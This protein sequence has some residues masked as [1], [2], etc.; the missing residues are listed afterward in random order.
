LYV[1]PEPALDAEMF[2]PERPL[3]TDGNGGKEF[4]CMWTRSLEYSFLIFRPSVI[5]CAGLRRPYLPIFYKVRMNRF[6]VSQSK[7]L[8]THQRPDR[9]FVESIVSE[10]EN[11]S[12]DRSDQV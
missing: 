3:R 11:G 12:N 6:A 7:Q 10:V 1:E 9:H 2:S 8:R 4:N 5:E